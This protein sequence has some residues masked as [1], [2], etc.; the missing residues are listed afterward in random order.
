MVSTM[1]DIHD[2]G[3]LSGPL[4]GVSFI[5]GVAGA[6]ALA[7]APYPRPGADPA[8]IRRY[9]RGNP[10]AARISV[11]GQLISAA[12][13]ARFTAS[14]AKLAGRSGRRSRGLRAGAIAGGGLAAASL[15]TS[16]L[17]S[18]ALTG[19]RGERDASAAEL[20]R[21]MFAAGGPVHGAG[22]GILVGLLGLAVLRTGELPLPLAIAGLVSAAAGVLSPL[23]LVTERAVWLIPVGRFSGLVVS[24]IAGAILERRSSER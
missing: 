2:S 7:D 9:F 3:A 20:H 12:S 4:A 17:F 14:V 13:L 11:V 15:T 24:A 21:L 1:T 19:D 23:Y 5:I 16:A 22:F 6:M 10:G 18:A 8:E